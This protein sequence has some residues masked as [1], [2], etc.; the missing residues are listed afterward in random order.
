MPVSISRLTSA[1]IPA[2]IDLLHIFEAV[3]E[4]EDFELPAN[5]YL[6]K[7]LSNKD[8]LVMAARDENGKVL[9]GLT[10]YVLPSYY[11]ETAELYLYDLGVSPDAQRQG[12]G[13]LLLDSL[14]DYCKKGKFTE[15]FVQAVEGDT[16]AMRFYNATGGKPLRVIHY[17]YEL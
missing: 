12:I 3:F 5:S 10:A 11:E 2:M 8:F 13:R 6:D 16:E 4:M 7:L 1:D 9:G 15:F 14:K 17:D